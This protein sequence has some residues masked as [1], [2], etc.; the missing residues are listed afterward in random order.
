MKAENIKFKQLF[1]FHL[2][3]LHDL[4]EGVAFDAHDLCL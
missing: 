4:S 3:N 2:D 1:E